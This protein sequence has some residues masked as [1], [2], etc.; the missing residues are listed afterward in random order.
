M[1]W[2]CRNVGMVPTE[3]PLGRVVKVYPGQDGCICENVSWHLSQTCNQGCCVDPYWT[4]YDCTP[5]LSY[6]FVR[7]PS[8]MSWPAGMLCFTHQICLSGN[9]HTIHL[10]SYGNGHPIHLY[11][12]YC[13]VD[14]HVFRS[15]QWKFWTVA[16]LQLTISSWLV[17][18][19]LF[20]VWLWVWFWMRYI[21]LPFKFP[22]WHSLIVPPHI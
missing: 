8:G 3:W 5:V 11:T 10:L 13:I 21:G 4:S 20:L 18:Y 15:E 17:Q 14:F 6:A 1:W 9:G 2:F 19:H 7:H 12:T 16:R 22:L